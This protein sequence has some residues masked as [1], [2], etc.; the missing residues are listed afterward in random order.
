VGILA[1]VGLDIVSARSGVITGSP[2][3]VST[4]PG[5]VSTDPGVVSTDPGVVSTRINDLFRGTIFVLY[6]D[7]AGRAA[8]E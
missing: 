8:Q 6:P 2:G 7:A 1:V 5:V 4:D 3:V